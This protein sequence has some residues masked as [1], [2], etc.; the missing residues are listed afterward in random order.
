MP[1]EF[2]KMVNAI[3]QSL[4]KANPKMK[5]EDITSKAYAMAT[6]S[7]KKSHGGK[8]PSE[9]LNNL[10]NL[11]NVDNLDSVDSLSERLNDWRVL[12]FFVPIEEKVFDKDTDEFLI[13]GVAINETTTLNNVKYVAQELEK[14]SSSFRNVPI[15]LDHKN[16]IKNIVGRTTN[17]VNFNSANRRI[18]FEGKIMDKTIREMI[19][20]GRI[21]NVSIGAKVDDL[22]EETDG[23]KKAVGIRGLEISLV[24]VPGDNQANL[25][26]A[27][28]HNF[29]LKEMANINAN[30]YS[31]HIEHTEISNEEMLKLAQNIIDEFDKKESIDNSSSEQVSKLNLKED[32]MAEDTAVKDIVDSPKQ[33]ENPE[34]TEQK[35]E[36]VN[37]QNQIDELKSLIIS[38]FSE[39]KKIQ[40]SKKEEKVNETKG[41]VSTEKVEASENSNDFIVESAENGKGFSLYSDYSKNSK[42]KR[43]SR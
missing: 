17:N 30:R 25:A 23:S 35:S 4:R 8:A 39:M 36:S 40:E 24:A 42:L 10:N 33:V 15:L 14:A 32:N 13:R 28:N 34:Q 41:I 20:D 16:E 38:S 9:M 26:Q 31:K 37:T 11:D 22:V 1:T 27:I 6:A 2:D 5:E 21:Q 3:K 18:D 19:K 43:L 12:E 29:H 7:W